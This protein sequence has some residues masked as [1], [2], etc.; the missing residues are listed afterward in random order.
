MLRTTLRRREEMIAQRTSSTRM[1]T[2]TRN[3]I[4]FHCDSICRDA[5][6]PFTLLDLGL[7]RYRNN[8]EIPLLLCGQGLCYRARSTMWDQALRDQR[9]PGRQG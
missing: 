8:H 1:S 7:G 5:G 6:L 3:S 9:Y 4:E 2:P